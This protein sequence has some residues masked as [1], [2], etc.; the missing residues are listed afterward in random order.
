MTIAA[1]PST[2][3]NTINRRLDL[4]ETLQTDD[5]GRAEIMGVL[6][7]THDLQRILQKFSLGRGSVDD[8]IS[9]ARTIKSTEELVA[10][11]SSR[12]SPV[13]D[14]VNE[15]LKP[16]SQLAVMILESIDEEGLH[17]QQMQ[18]A[19]EAAAYV[20]AA[21]EESLVV[22]KPEEVRKEVKKS[23]ARATASEMMEGGD[24]P[25]VMKKKFVRPMRC[26]SYDANLNSA[27]GVLLECHARLQALREA[28]GHLEVHLQ[29]KFRVY[30]L[31]LCFEQR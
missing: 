24:E 22:S 20:E 5:V 2:D 26:W 16:P 25:W 8:L 18:E 17:L 9:I 31:L 12:N 29:N 15:T 23:I 10:L 4:V 14:A 13:F 7:R 6:K 19:E 21:A 11:L 30:P 28:K 27:S 3:V 1:S